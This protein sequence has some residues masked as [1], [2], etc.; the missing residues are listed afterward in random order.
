MKKL[1]MQ[2]RAIEEVK[3]AIKPFYQN[4][5]I[6]KEEYKEILRKAVQKVKEGIRGIS[7]YG[8]I[9]S[10]RNQFILSH[11][12][13]CFVSDSCY[14]ICIVCSLTAIRLDSFRCDV[15]LEIAL[16][17][18]Q[19]LHLL[20]CI[21]LP[22]CRCVTARAEKSIRSRWPTWWRRTLINTGMPGNTRSRRRAH[23]VWV[24][25]VQPSPRLKTHR[26]SECSPGSLLIH[27][28]KF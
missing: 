4:R 17:W 26:C 14:G 1:H 23:Q 10:H 18:C 22:S 2:E 7:E 3:L 8:H 5:D 6:T 28:I 21:L 11:L 16:A 13:S 25:L 24:E 15:W 12:L 19:V 27:M 9:Y 20:T